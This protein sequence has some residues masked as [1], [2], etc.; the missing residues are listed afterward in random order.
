MYEYHCMCWCNEKPSTLDAPEPRDTHHYRLDDCGLAD[1]GTLSGLLTPNIQGSQGGGKVPGVPWMLGK[2]STTQSDSQTV[3]LV[4]APMRG[5]GG[6]GGRRTGCVEKKSAPR[7]AV[8]DV[9]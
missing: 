1:S 4:G 9:M 7:S 3:Y 6:S 5:A 8:S 2:L